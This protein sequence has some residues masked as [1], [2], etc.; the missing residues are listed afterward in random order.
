MKR[1]GKWFALLLSLS[2]LFS[3][4]SACGNGTGSAG[5]EAETQSEAASTSAPAM[6]Q[7]SPEEERAASAESVPDNATSAPDELFVDVALP[8]VEERETLSMW[9]G[10][11]DGG[12]F[13]NDNPGVTLMS[14]AA[15]EATNVEIDYRFCSGMDIIDQTS[16][17]FA[18]GDWPD[19]FRCASMYSGGLSAGVEENVF[20]N[21]ADYDLEQN[22][23]NYYARITSNDDLYKQ[24]STDEG[25]LAKYYTIYDEPL[26]QNTGLLVRTDYLDQLGLSLPETY[27]DWHTMLQGFKND[28]GLA[29]PFILDTSGLLDM[30]TAGYGVNS[31]WYQ[32]DGQVY[33]APVQE[34]FR[35]YLTMVN[36]WYAEGLIHQD[37]I[38]NTVS[39]E[40]LN[41][42]YNGT[43][44]AYVD[45]YGSITSFK[46]LSEDPN[47]ASS[48]V[49]A[50][51]KKAGDQTHFYA[52]GALVG[53]MDNG[54]IAI[55]TSCENVELC[56]RWMDFFYSEKGS[57][58]F[59][60]GLEGETYTDN[61]DGTYSFT[62]L[63]TN[64]PD[65]PITFARLIYLDGCAGTGLYRSAAKD[66]NLDEGS[67]EAEEI[68]GVSD[69]AYVIPSYDL[70][71]TD[72]STF[73]AIMGDI[74]TYVDEMV[75]KFITG[76]ES[77]DGFDDY[78]ATIEAMGLPK[79]IALKQDGLDRYNAR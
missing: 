12:N 29:E 59:S 33:Y 10:G 56:M 21:L 58:I 55:S 6:E 61:G 49:S 8:L 4:I 42:I 34:G 44:G 18:S 54:G 76:A 23:P 77:L 50:P 70:N 48:A 46:L 13:G 60:Y 22:S 71:G 64:N 40:R 52:G 43:C 32:I 53:N 78:A 66:I 62:E 16:L 26:R 20:L 35:E 47:F 74:E 45:D 51:V 38:N 63:I 57:L 41:K 17:V 69:N 75:L 24:V 14:Q 37:F 36:Q 25:Y 27:D 30:L 5:S 65:W 72:A 9:W 19:M 11:Y 31:S 39:D 2:L 7:N 68:W 15:I 73:A 79:A 1:Y 3:M 67:L 28:L